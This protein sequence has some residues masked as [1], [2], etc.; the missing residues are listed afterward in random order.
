MIRLCFV[1]PIVLTL[2]VVAYVGLSLVV[3]DGLSRIG[4][5]CDDNRANRPDHF[6]CVTDCDEW[7]DFDFEA[8]SMPTY[9]EVHFPSRDGL[10]L[11]GWYIATD[12]E[13]ATIIVVHGYQVCK[14]HHHPL[15]QAG[16]LYRAG[17]NVL[18]FDQRDCGDSQTEDGR[19]AYGSEEYLDALGAFD[20]LRSRGFADASIGMHG[21][22]LGGAITLTAFAQ[23]PGLKTIFL[24]S[25]LTDGRAQFTQYTGL[26]DALFPGVEWAARIVSG[27][28]LLRHNPLDAIKRAGGRR[29]AVV[30]GTDDEIVRPSHTERLLQV[31][32]QHDVKIEAWRPKGVGHVGALAVHPQEYER[33]MAEFFIPEDPTGP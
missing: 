2:A 17:F 31:A 1:L 11:S 10:Q 14:Y 19:S 5:V 4:S 23:E 28:T 15:A 26:P 30:H 13:A 8:Y 25:P 7:Q 24:D 18:L 33:R 12:P 29:L 20:F 3:Y 6:G 32:A 22:S 9:E 27:D 16:A 21:S